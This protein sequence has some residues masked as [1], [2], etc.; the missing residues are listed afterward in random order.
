MHYALAFIALIVVGGLS[1][2]ATAIL[3]LDWQITQTYWVVSHIHYV[4]VGANMFPVFAALYYWFPKMSGRMLSETLGKISFWVMFAGF[5]MAFFT[6]HV[7]GVEGMPRR[8]YTYPSGMG[9][10][11]LNLLITVGA[12]ILAVG[13]LLTLINVFTSLKSGE[14]AGR[15]PWFADTLEWST[16]SPPPPYGSVHIPTVVSRH[17]LWDEHEEEE[18]PTGERILDQGRL[19]FS[20]S[21]LDGNAFAVSRMPEDT[22]KPLLAAIGTSVV[23]GAWVDGLIWLALVG[24]IFTLGSV[25]LWLWPPKEGKFA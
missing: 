7:T 17:P 9:W 24:T 12:F 25:S 20:T 23:V 1:G 2:V 6:M 21:W 19:T 4:L 22:I 15:N 18:D 16:E 11:G 14:L 3:P 5:N 8:I 10:G 13:I